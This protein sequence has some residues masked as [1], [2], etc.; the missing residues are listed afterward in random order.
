MA[1]KSK[2]YKALIIYLQFMAL[3]LVWAGIS[4]FQNGTSDLYLLGFIILSIATFCQIKAYQIL[5]S[6]GDLS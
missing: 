1:A 6:K 5:L 2:R 3:V 4:I